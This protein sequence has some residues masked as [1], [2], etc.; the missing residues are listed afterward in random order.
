VSV[1]LSGPKKVREHKVFG[2]NAALAFLKV[3]P[4]D[5]VRLYVTDQ[6]VPLFKKHMKQL[7]EDKKAYHIVTDEEMH[8]ISEESLHHEGVCLLVRARPPLSTDEAIVLLSSHKKE[9]S[10]LVVVLENVENP[11]NLG[12][13]CRVVAHFGTQ[14]IV[15]KRPIDQTPPQWNPAFYRTAEGGADSTPI[16]LVET[17]APLHKATIKLGYQWVATSS[18]SKAS[19]WKSPF[20]ARTVILLGSEKEG[21]SAETLKLASLHVCL[22]GTGAV[23]SL[24]VAC[25]A[26][27]LI[28]EFRR[29]HP[30]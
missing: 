3:R 12:A 28:A 30:Q 11:H 18:H 23:E 22:P 19:V 5:V 6:N 10:G 17:L 2:K 4:G 20:A 21:L 14:L 24:N 7:A 25:A 1:V 29:S 26:T 9:S 8:K 27:A 16:C 13:L 15:L